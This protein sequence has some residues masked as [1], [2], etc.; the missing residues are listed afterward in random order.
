MKLRVTA[1]SVL[2]LL[3][4]AVRQA[5]GVTLGNRIRTAP[6]PGLPGIPVFTHALNDCPCV[7]SPRA[8][9]AATSSA[10]AG[11]AAKSGIASLET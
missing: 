8:G 7:G 2:A 6:V 1:T 3:L 4:V 11:R 5:D 10:S 9:E